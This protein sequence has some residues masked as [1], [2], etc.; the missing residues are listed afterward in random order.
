MYRAITRRSVLNS[1][2]IGGAMLALDACGGKKQPAAN[3]RLA[4][5]VTYLTGFGTTPREGYP[6]VAKGAGY[7]TDQHL[8]IT[9]AAGAP[10]DANL[11]TLAAGK[12]D[13]AAVDFVSAVRG[14]KTYPNYRVVMAVQSVTL[15]SMITLPSHHIAVPH[16]LAGKTL[17]TAPAAAT[18]TLFPTY[19]K[20]AGFDPTT[21]TFVNFSPDQLPAVMTTDKIDAMGGYAIDT[22]GIQA[23][24]GGTLPVVLPY[25]T[26]ITDLYGTVIVATSDIINRNPDLVRRFTTAMWKGIRYAVNNPPMAGTLMHNA[27]PTV[28]ADTMTTTMELMHPYITTP[29][30]DPSRLMRG[31]ALLEQ[32]Q[33]ADPGTT[34]SQVVDL[35]FAPQAA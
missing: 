22:P 17:G 4:D 5:K 1:A 29:E 24:A 19:A 27:V 26:Y 12:A 18:Q 15:L 3:G 6:W 2:A 20:L 35:R 10:S 13:F 28:S 33:L 8:D 25:N 9:V 23:A 30:L 21:V 11:K 32:A 31:I 34:P 14:V 16:D 7:F